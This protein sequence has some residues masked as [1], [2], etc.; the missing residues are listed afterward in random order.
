[1]GDDL[2]CDAGIYCLASCKNTDTLTKFQQTYDERAQ[3][4]VGRAGRGGKYEKGI[5]V[6]VR[7]VVDLGLICRK[8]V[9]T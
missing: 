9:Y 1:M 7:C 5:K 4:R 6:G 8:Y 3:E 2:V